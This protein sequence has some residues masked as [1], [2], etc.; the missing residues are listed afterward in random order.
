MSVY[1]MG[2]FKTKKHIDL[3]LIALG[4]KITENFSLTVQVCITKINLH[5]RSLADLTENGFQQIIFDSSIVA[6]SSSRPFTFFEV[7]M[8]ESNM[9]VSITFDLKVSQNRY[10][11]KE[12]IIKQ[13]RLKSTR[14]NIKNNIK[15]CKNQG[16]VKA[17]VGSDSSLV[18]GNYYEDG[19]T[20]VMDMA[21]FYVKIRHVFWDTFL[22]EK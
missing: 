21:S 1:E 5:Y 7:N 16:G 10:H 13:N 9:K 6:G 14:T 19:E 15:L 4:E 2:I 22:F 11:H 18:S 17:A 8:C 20:V 3:R 12:S